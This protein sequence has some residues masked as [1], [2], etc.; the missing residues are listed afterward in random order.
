M[1][2]WSVLA[3][4]RAFIDRRMHHTHTSY[5]KVYRKP[6]SIF[7]AD[8]T[9]CEWPVLGQQHHGYRNGAYI[10]IIERCSPNKQHQNIPY[11]YGWVSVYMDIRGHVLALP[12]NYN[13]CLCVWCLY[14]LTALIYL[15]T[16]ICTFLFAVSLF[17]SRIHTHTH[18]LCSCRLSRLNGWEHFWPRP[19]V[20]RCACGAMG[21]SWICVYVR[22]CVLY[23]VH[24]YHLALKK[25][26]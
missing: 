1:S 13:V 10:N 25:F 9:R 8:K 18:T 16:W 4:Q 12:N 11:E 21:I 2:G 19:F 17:L 26:V 20:V 24:R 7:L 23:D 6:S 14:G 5:G 3:E 15:M 22:L